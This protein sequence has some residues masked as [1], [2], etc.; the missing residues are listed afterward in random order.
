MARNRAKDV[1]FPRLCQAI[2]SSR[3]ALRDT[4]DRRTEHIRQYA[5]A[6]Y[7]NNAS[8][9][10]VPGNLISQYVKIIL[11][12]LISKNPRVM[13]S[14]D[15]KQQRWKVNAFQTWLN[16]ATKKMNLA[17]TFAAS[18]FDGLFCM[19]VIKVALATPSDAAMA[20]WKLKAGY[21][22]VKRVDFDD[23]VIDVHARSP[24][25]AMFEGHRFR[26]PLKTIA[27]STLYSMARKDLQAAIDEPYNR[28]GDE[29]VNMIFRGYVT[30]TDEEFEP[31][32]DLWEI[33]L[34][35]ERLVVTLPNSWIEQG[36][37][38]SAKVEEPLRT[39]DWLGPDYGPYHRLYYDMPPPNN[40]LPKA[41]IMDLID[42][43]EAFNRAL[44][45]LINQ[46]DRQ[47]DNT[48]V[49]GQ[50]DADGKRVID[51][52]DGDIVRVDNPD[53][54]H[55]VSQGGPNPG[56]FAF[57]QNM[58]QLFSWL[59]GNLE[60]V[61]G[62]GPEAKTATQEEMLNQNASRGIQSMQASTV[63]HVSSVFD[64]LGWYLHHHPELVMETSYEVPGAPE[65]SIERRVTPGQR[66]QLPYEEMD[67]EV[68]PY[69]LAH[70]TPQTRSAGLKQ[71]MMQ[72]VM[73]MMPILQQQ[74]YGVAI[75]KLLEKLADY[76]D[77]PD[78]TD[79]VTSLGTPEGGEPQQQAGG[80][81]EPPAKMSPG[82]TTRNYVRESRSQATAG[83]QAKDMVS[84]LMGAT[85]AQPGQMNGFAKVR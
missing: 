45:K 57:M 59:G 67:I 62:L 83:G 30:G 23:Y 43:H 85:G 63:E 55:A 84:K 3:L 4:R 78:L 80:G 58:Q 79:I 68:N 52:S 39:V 36:G 6:N 65:A 34:P 20:G 73:P 64:A 77:M 5:G 81:G 8:P 49:Q 50:A 16:R 14:T 54:I 12:N 61:G 26:V 1:D 11:P 18:A 41:P 21:P 2:W 38:T 46:S 32:V 13:L 48:F 44:R 31:M 33:Y 28:E 69:S 15:N 66:R 17:R 47:K 10:R 56:L 82:E 76:D 72:I 19:G 27:K 51:A 35:L 9:L 25:E 70:A 7:G 74:G 37:G 53:K 71:L 60:T 75:G 29:R 42:I 24:E 40:L 22:Y